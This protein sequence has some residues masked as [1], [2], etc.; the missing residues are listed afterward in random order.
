MWKMIMLVVN[1]Y[2]PTDIP[3][4]MQLSFPTEQACMHAATSLSYTVKF[5]WFKVTAECKKES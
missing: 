1:I 2:D 3:G 5:D 4:R